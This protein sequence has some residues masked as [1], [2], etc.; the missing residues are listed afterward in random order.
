MIDEE[1]EIGRDHPDVVD[2]T[3]DGDA[4]GMRGHQAYSVERVRL[5]ES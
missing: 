4:R 2:D 1:I 5:R 3:K